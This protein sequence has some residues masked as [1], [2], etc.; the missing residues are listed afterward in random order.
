MLFIV[1]HD[2]KT[3]RLAEVM[4]QERK[5]TL[6]G[7]ADLTRMSCIRI[8]HPNTS[9]HSSVKIILSKTVLKQC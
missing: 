9:S 4:R 2:L 1:G 8:P 7:T 3:Y 6:L 5:I